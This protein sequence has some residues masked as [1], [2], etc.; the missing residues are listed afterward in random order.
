MCRYQHRDQGKWRNRD[1]FQTTEQSKFPE[2]N[3]NVVNFCD[4][5][6]EIQNY[7]NKEA[8][9]GQ[10]SNVRT[11]WEFQ[12]GDKKYE[13]VPKRNIR[14]EECYNCTENSIEALNNILV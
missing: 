12:Q 13:A 2:A 14:Y 10:G 8:H 11:S 9:R 1:I 4:L 5:P 6:K 7:G 3:L